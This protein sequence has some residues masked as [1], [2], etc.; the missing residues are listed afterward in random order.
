[1][2]VSQRALIY[3]RRA[4]RTQTKQ[5]LAALGLLFTACSRGGKLPEDVDLGGVPPS[6][7]L[8]TQDLS[9]R[10]QSMPSALFPSFGAPIPF[11][12]TG[13]QAGVAVSDLNADGVADILLGS[14]RPGGFK[15]YL[16]KGD[17]TLIDRGEVGGSLGTLATTFV[18]TADLNNDG[19]L[20]A[21]A[22]SYSPSRVLIALGKGDGTFSNSVSLPMP[23]TA[24]GIAATDLDRDGKLDLAVACAQGNQACILR[25]RGDG[26]FDAVRQLPVDKIPIGTAVADLD[27]DKLPDVVMA[28]YESQALDILFGKG[29]GTFRPLVKVPSDEGPNKLAIADLNSDGLPDLITSSDRAH[30]VTVHLGTG[31]GAFAPA[32]IY[33]TGKSAYGMA[34]LDLNRDGVL[35]VAVADLDTSVAIFLGRGDGTLSSARLIDTGAASAYGLAAGD[36]NRDGLNDLVVVSNLGRGGVLLLNTTATP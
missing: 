3:S 18:L 34:V 25:G 9:V 15:I 22:N 24:E 36:F 29:D 27:G 35:D 17:G 8:R 33:P 32:R 23:P 4:M 16:G 5:T 11:M 1:V 14:D 28:A 26:N 7:D 10:D 12:T 21:I 13:T 19:K 31:A 2:I 20:D 30:G 6:S